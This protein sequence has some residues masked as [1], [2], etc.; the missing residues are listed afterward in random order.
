MREAARLKG[1]FAIAYADAFAAQV[2]AEKGIPLI[3]G[4]KELSLLEREG[5]IATLSQNM[6]D[7]IGKS[8]KPNLKVFFYLT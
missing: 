1:R 3:T 5:L 2:A 4:D 7:T 6:R 8:L